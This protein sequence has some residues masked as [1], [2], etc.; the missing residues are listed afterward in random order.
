MLSFHLVS[1]PKTVYWRFHL[2]NSV[3]IFCLPI[4]DMQLHNKPPTFRRFSVNR[5]YE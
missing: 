3:R 4:L 2:Q 1:L 5:R